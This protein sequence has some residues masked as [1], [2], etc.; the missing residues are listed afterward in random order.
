MAWGSVALD[1]PTTYEVAVLS[2]ELL[3]LRARDLSHLRRIRLCVAHRVRSG[4]SA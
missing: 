4:R 1:D 2:A 3:W